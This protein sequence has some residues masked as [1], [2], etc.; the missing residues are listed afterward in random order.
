MSSNNNTL[1]PRYLLRW[2]FKQVCAEYIEFIAKTGRYFFYTLDLLRD[3]VF[4][5]CD[6][7][8]NSAVA[9]NTAL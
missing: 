1:L 5:S 3:L 4:F 6:A 2:I 7:T 8:E 9:L